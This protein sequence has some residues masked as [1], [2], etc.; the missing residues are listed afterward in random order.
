[1]K[2]NALNTE[3][4]RNIVSIEMWL[5]LCVNILIFFNQVDVAIS[6]APNT[7]MK[8]NIVSMWLQLCVNILIFFNQ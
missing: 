4:K 1:M 3:M 6:Y 5:Q 7:E 2:L 8:R